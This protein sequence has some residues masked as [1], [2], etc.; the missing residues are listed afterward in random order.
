MI[1]KHKLDP[2]AC[3]P[4]LGTVEF[5]K[6]ASWGKK[7]KSKTVNGYQ[8]VMD[9]PIMWDQFGDLYNEIKNVL[10]KELNFK[11]KIHRSWVV[12]YNKGGWQDSHTH[13]NSIKSCVV[14]L[15]GYGDGILEFETGDKFDMHQGDMV[16]FDSNTRHWAHH[17]QL[18][19]TV[20]SFDISQDGEI[21]K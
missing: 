17:V 8:P 1:T 6:D 3:M 16:L 21:Q 20:L 11:W 18:P 7:A 12:S 4:L 19:K 5:F 15:L 13:H 2:W 14:C 10:D 9:N